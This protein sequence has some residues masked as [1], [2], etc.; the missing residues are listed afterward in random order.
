MKSKIKSSFK[1]TIFVFKK[2]NGKGY[3]VFNSLSKIVKITTLSLSYSIVLL[4]LQVLSQ[5]DTTI[6]K[7]LD[8]EEVIIS[9]QRAPIIY[10]QLS[11]HVTTIN[12]DEIQLMPVSSLDEILENFSGIDVRQRGANGIQSDI[13][14]RGGSFDQNLILLNGVNISDP[15][16]GHHSLNLPIDLNS[17]ERIE[18]LEGPGS[19][20]FGPNAFS[21][22]INI[23]TNQ[24]D[25]NYTKAGFTAGDFGLFSGNLVS[26]I[27]LKK[28]KQFISFSKSRS[29]GYIKN[30]DYEQNNIFY[31]LNYGSDIGKID[32]QIGYTD[33]E[34]GA[35]SF[36]TPQ[37]PDQ[38]EQI[39]TTFTSLKFETGDKI[40]ISPKVYFRR[41]KDRF[42]LFRYEPESWYTGHNYHLTDVYGV[43]VDA[44]MNTKIGITSVGVELRS[45]NIWSN[46]LGNLMNDTIKVKGE[47]DGFYSKTYSR[48]ISNLFLE[49][50]YYLGDFSLTGGLLAS[51]VSENDLGFNLYPGIDLGYNFNTKTKVY[52]TVNKSLRLPTFTDLF[53]SGPSNIG[54]SDLKP[55]VAWSY[56]AG[57]KFKENR[58]T[59]NLS[60]YYRDSK[61]LIAWVKPLNSDPDAKWETQNLTNVTTFGF[62][63]SN[64]LNVNKYSIQNLSFNYSY[65]HQATLSDESFETKYSLNYLKHNFVFNVNHKLF[66]YMNLSWSTKYQDRAGSYIKYDVELNDYVGDRNFDPFWLFDA[67]LSWSKKLL[68]IYAQATNIFNSKYTDISNVEAPGRLF[69]AGFNVQIDYF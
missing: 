60:F 3:A 35:N 16:T 67:K 27:K 41:H 26:S 40:K 31:N 45:E 20:V 63:L 17:I 23:I 38:Y 68:T 46:V 14:I 2:W 12:E 44:K 29:N 9:A 18:I 32:F 37:Y 69:Q 34:F 51:W 11:R 1:Q 54:N 22:A 25:K 28:T 56:E 57:L 24:S 58:I 48:T 50:S 8:L 62:E 4:P 36:Y 53:Y 59:S 19:R 15:Q 39:K 66:D 7:N 65:L 21:G 55:E 33:K 13:S 47:P 30:T 10:S 42:E 5:A 49:H 6:T 43:K 64:Q 52:L 61:N